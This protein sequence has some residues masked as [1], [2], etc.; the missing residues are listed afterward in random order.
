MYLS[1]KV[2]EEQSGNVRKCVTTLRVV[3]AALDFKGSQCSYQLPTGI[4]HAERA[5]RGGTLQ[6]V[7]Q[8][9]RGCILSG[10]SDNPAARMTCGPAQI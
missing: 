10:E 3:N 8:N 6:P 9:R 2:R 5:E 7:R 1:A 4:H